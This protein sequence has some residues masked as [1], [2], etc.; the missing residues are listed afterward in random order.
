MK[1]ITLT[2]NLSGTREMI[3]FDYVLKLSETKFSSSG[4]ADCT[5][6]TMLDI[7]SFCVRESIAEI[8]R[9]LQGL[10]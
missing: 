8:T 4:K 2:H 3:N 7:E 1:L 5:T 9:K 10:L 6:I